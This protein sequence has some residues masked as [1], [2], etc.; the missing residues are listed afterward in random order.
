MAANA[1]PPLLGLDSKTLQGH[2]S[3]KKYINKFLQ[4]HNFH[5]LLRQLFK[6]V[7]VV[8]LEEIV[9]VLFR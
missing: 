8:L 9:N 7:K 3:S 4:E 2:Y 1:S 5:V 6:L